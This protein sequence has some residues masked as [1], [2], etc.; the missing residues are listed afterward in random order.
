[1]CVLDMNESVGMSTVKVL[2][3]GIHKEVCWVQFTIPYTLHLW[4]MSGDNMA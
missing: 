1:M 2:C 4:M 3:Q